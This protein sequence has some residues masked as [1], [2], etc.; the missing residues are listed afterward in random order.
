M[1]ARICSLPYFAGEGADHRA[2]QA[3]KFQGGELASGSC[4]HQCADNPSS[5]AKNV[6]MIAVLPTR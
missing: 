5:C 1:R 3:S 4:T 2:H 6:N